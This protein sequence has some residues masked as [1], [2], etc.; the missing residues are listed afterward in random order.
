MSNL[1]QRLIIATEQRN[2]HPGL[3]KYVSP[4]VES[5][6][7]LKEQVRKP[8]V[9]PTVAQ[10]VAQTLRPTGPALKNIQV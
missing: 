3:A 10:T 4:A 6:Q 2:A 1:T 8:Y 9:A 5:L 7:A